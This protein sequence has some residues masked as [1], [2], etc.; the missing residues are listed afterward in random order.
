MTEQQSEIAKNFL[1][2]VIFLGGRLRSFKVI[3]F[4]NTKMLVSSV[5]YYRQQFCVYLQPLVC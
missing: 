4:G 5:G 1:K 2:P 3:D